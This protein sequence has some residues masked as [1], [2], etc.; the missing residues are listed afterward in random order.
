M[1]VEQRKNCLEV[2]AVV[3]E[4]EEAAV[5]PFSI[6]QPLAQVYDVKADCRGLLTFLAKIHR[7]IEASSSSE[8]SYWYL[9]LSSCDR[10]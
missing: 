9:S 3:V 5:M 10:F 6:I 4:G 7:E 2:V 8:Q 1:R